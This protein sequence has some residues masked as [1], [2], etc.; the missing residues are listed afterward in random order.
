MNDEFLSAYREAPSREFSSDLYGQLVQMPS[1]GAGFKLD[2]WRKAILIAAIALLAPLMVAMTVSPDARAAIQ[3]VIQTIG[4]MKYHVSNDYPGGSE[5]VQTI[6]S[7]TMTLAEARAALSFELR[8]P[9][10]APEGYIFEDVVTVTQWPDT[11][12]TS[13]MCIWQS[14]T[15]RVI[16]T[17][18][19]APSRLGYDQ[20]MIGPDSIREVQVRGLPG[21][22]VYGAWNLNAR[23]WSKEGIMTLHWLEDGLSYALTGM[24]S[25]ITEEDLLRMAESIP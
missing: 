1:G 7:Q 18:N 11:P 5:P 20:L 6:P 8:L 22:L 15:N 23:A 25:G 14:D 21:S 10:Q 19:N 13:A 9:E 2:D 17:I 24:Q 3:M 16:L 12:M 4:G